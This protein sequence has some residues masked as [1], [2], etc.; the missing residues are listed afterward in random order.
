M[1]MLV[2]TSSASLLAAAADTQTCIL[3][4]SKSGGNWIQSCL[5]EIFCMQMIM[6]WYR[7]VFKTWYGI[8]KKHNGDE[9][10]LKELL[11]EYLECILS[12]EG[13]SFVAHALHKKTNAPVSKK[14]SPP[15]LKSMAFASFI[16][17]WSIG[18]NT[19][20]I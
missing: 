8:H 16:Q 18:R 7:T 3:T 13:T 19:A 1:M 2:I 9:I 10:F 12:C 14:S 5:S 4:R 6:I 17:I 11:F 15:F 20:V